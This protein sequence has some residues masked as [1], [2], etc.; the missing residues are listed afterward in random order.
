MT[1]RDLRQRDVH[2]RFRS[3]SSAHTI[4]C[5][6]AGTVAHP[7]KCL[8][9]GSRVAV[10]ELGRQIDARPIQIEE[11][12]VKVSSAAHDPE[13]LPMLLSQSKALPIGTISKMLEHSRGVRREKGDFPA[14]HDILTAAAMVAEDNGQLESFQIL[15]YHPAVDIGEGGAIIAPR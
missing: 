1:P 12:N 14:V 11:G 9:I 15:Q 3:F 7:Q 10:K 8:L 13:I 2:I 5:V 6:P 4:S